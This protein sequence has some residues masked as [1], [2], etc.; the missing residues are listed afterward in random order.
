MEPRKEKVKKVICSP[1]TYRECEARKLD[2]NRRKKLGCPQR[3]GFLMVKKSP[4]LESDVKE[5]KIKFLKP[6]RLRPLPFL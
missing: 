3:E 2:S 4:L 5:L 6:P 1:V